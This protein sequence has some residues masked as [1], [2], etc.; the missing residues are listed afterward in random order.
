MKTLKLIIASAL[1]VLLSSCYYNSR[2]I[3]LQDKHFSEFTPTLIQNKKSIYRLQPSD[4]ISVQVKSSNETDASNT[5]FNVTS[6]QNGL[7]TTPGSLFLEG[8]TI[9]ASGKIML[10]I[11]GEVTV[12]D[13]TIEDAQRVIQSNANK[14]LK[15][16]TVIVKLTSFKVTVL[17]EVKNPGYLYVY[18]NQATILEV[19]GLAGDLTP[20]ANRKNIKLIRQVPTGS[21]VILLNLTDPKLISSEYFFLMPNDVLYI[22]PLKARANKTNL[23]ILGVVFAGLTTLVLILSYTK[24]Y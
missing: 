5:I 15:N 17:G 9:D 22:E 24:Q 11:I 8:Y 19:L 21:Q 3:Y 1:S 18:N 2:L 16:S 10:P 7:Y 13:L 4:I 14:Y 20:F 6:H 23:E 12:K